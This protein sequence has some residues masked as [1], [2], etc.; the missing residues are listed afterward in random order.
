MLE[1]VFHQLF[2]SSTVYNHH[3][4]ITY[5]RSSFACNSRPIINLDHFEH[6]PITQKTYLENNYK[7]KK[8]KPEKR[9]KNL[10]RV[11]AHYSHEFIRLRQKIHQNSTRSSENNH[12]K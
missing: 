7:T 5:H 12:L 1:T 3:D 11:K 2:I 8:E 4:H 10:R 6:K 9:K